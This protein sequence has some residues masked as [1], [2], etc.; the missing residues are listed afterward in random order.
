[1]K[2]DLQKV[3]KACAILKL[4]FE[5]IKWDSEPIIV[6]SVLDYGF[7]SS[8]GTKYTFNYEGKMIEDPKRYYTSYVY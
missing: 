1:M 3:K 4:S 2:S 6:V 7:G 8:T 5:E